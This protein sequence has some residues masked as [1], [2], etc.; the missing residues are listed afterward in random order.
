MSGKTSYFSEQSIHRQHW[1]IIEF[2]EE[3]AQKLKECLC[4][5]HPRERSRSVFFVLGNT[6]RWLL[7]GAP[8]YAA[9][10]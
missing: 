4:L 9:I 6:A 8:R 2:A 5:I 7:D 1:R 3:S 10:G